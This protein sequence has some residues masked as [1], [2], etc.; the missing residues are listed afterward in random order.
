[1]AQ[2]AQL[3]HRWAVADAVAPVLRVHTRIP[4]LSHLHQR[5]A[6]TQHAPPS[7][8]NWQAAEGKAYSGYDYAKDTTSTSYDSALQSAYDSWQV[9]CAAAAGVPRLPP[10][11]PLLLLLLLLQLPL[12]LQLPLCEAWV[13]PCGCCYLTHKRK[14][15][16]T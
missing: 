6:C 2:L 7:F 11:L 14:L 13:A 8:H 3:L 5:Q 10:P 16:F 4:L 12:P 9:G 15:R 1:M